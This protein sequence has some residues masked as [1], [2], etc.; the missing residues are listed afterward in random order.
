MD[1]RQST[2]N[3]SEQVQS[4]VKAFSARVKQVAPDAKIIVFGSQASGKAT[5]QSDIDVCVVSSKWSS[6]YHAGTLTLLTIAH[7][8]PLP[9]DVIPYSPEDFANKYDALAKEVRTNGIHVFA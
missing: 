1:T 9:M 3:F 8:F 7:E 4:Q 5:K 2:V 6:D